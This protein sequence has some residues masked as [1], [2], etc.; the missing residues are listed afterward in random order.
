MSSSNHN[1]KKGFF[2]P[3]GMSTLNLRLCVGSFFFCVFVIGLY[4]TGNSQVLP[5]KSQ[6]DSSKI[7]RYYGH[8]AVLDCYGVI[9]PWYHQPNGQCDYRIRIAAETLKRYPWTTTKNA[10]ISAPD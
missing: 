3:A 8:E 6:S 9:A 1:K 10:V 7:I 2:N 4:Y 5:L